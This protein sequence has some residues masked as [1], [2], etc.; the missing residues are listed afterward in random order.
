MAE[1]LTFGL[2][3]DQNM[4]WPTTVARWRLFESLGFDSLWNCDHFE[5]T[6]NPGAPYFE[7]WTQ[8]A[9]LAVMT[10]RAR[11][12]TLVSSNTFRHPGLL[13]REAVTVDHIS[14]GRLVRAGA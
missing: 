3:L 14:N 2:C 13:A 1:Q 8:L 10:E 9:G 7:A 12:G 11:I 5:Q 6:S 4:D